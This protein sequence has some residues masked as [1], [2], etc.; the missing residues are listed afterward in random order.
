[1][2]VCKVD[3]LTGETVREYSC[4]SS[5]ESCERDLYGE[6]WHRATID[7][8]ARTGAIGHRRYFWETK[9]ARRESFLGKAGCP[10]RFS[11]ENAP[12][13]YYFASST[14]AAKK[15][16]ITRNAVMSALARGAVVRAKVGGRNVAGYVNWWSPEMG[17]GRK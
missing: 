8:Q 10:V 15:L 12:R 13:D 14:D 9:G 2:T 17:R 4:A 7:Y 16:G 11:L 1:M 3:K 5:A 6:K